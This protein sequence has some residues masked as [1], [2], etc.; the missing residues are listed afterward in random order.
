M[1]GERV[2]FRRLAVVILTVLGVAYGLILTSLYVAQRSILFPAPR[3][4]R[5]PTPSSQLIVFEKA[6]GKKVYALYR[7]AAPGRPTVVHFHGNAEQ[8]ADDEWL[9]VWLEKFGIGFFAPEYPGYG[10]AVAEGNPSEASIFSTAELALKH[11]TEVLGVPREGLILSG[12]SLGSGVAVHLASRGVGARLLLFTPYTS[13]PD[14]A[15]Q[16]FPVA[17][18]RLLVRDRFDSAAKAGEV[19]VKVLVVHGTDDEVIPY[20]LGKRLSGQFPAGAL[21]TVEGGHHND[22]WE[23][24][25]VLDAVERFLTA[26]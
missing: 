15:A 3:E 1:S 24:R 21:F 6:S 13:I 17:P 8:I 12:Q 26:P 7:P 4:G 19:G 14:V 16:I 11:L 9:A 23:R 22:L 18:V 20:A 2:D 10:L 5:P 25:E